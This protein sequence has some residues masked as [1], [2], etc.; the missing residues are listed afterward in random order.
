MLQRALLNLLPALLALAF[1]SGT[2]GIGTAAPEANASTWNASAPPAVRFLV[3]RSSL[4][5]DDTDGPISQSADEDD[6][7]DGRIVRPFVAI[8]WPKYAR[9][10]IQHRREG[11]EPSH[12]PRAAPSRAPPIA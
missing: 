12:P 3:V 2:P 1:L 9:P 8:V 11:I 5:Q 10:P 7:S 4:V 6:T